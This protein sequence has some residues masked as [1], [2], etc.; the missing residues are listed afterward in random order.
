VRYLIGRKGTAE[1]RTCGGTFA[2][3]AALSGRHSEAPAQLPSW[4]LEFQIGK[5][6]D[7][8]TSQTKIGLWIMETRYSAASLGWQVLRASIQSSFTGLYSA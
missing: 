6:D 4:N 3:S 8:L 1:A 7:D 5:A 2:F